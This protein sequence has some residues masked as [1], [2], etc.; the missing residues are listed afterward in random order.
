MDNQK[1]PPYFRTLW[2]AMGDRLFSLFFGIDKSDYSRWVDYHFDLQLTAIGGIPLDVIQAG[3]NIT[4][5]SFSEGV[6]A[7]GSPG[8]LLFSALSGLCLGICFNVLKAA[9]ENDRLV[10]AALFSTY[11]C[12][13]VLFTWLNG[14]GVTALFHIS[15]VLG[16]LM[17]YGLIRICLYFC[18]Y[19]SRVFLSAS[20][21]KEARTTGRLL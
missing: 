12:F 6:I 4:G 5:T 20:Y 8:Y 2:P 1:F 15:V 10:L 21:P 13:P 18:G 9:I 3:H 17:T 11:F 14:G 7:L 19:D 16:F